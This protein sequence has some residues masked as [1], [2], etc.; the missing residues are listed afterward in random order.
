MT[1]PTIDEQIAAQ[2]QLLENY[3]PNP[4]VTLVAQSILESLRHYKAIM[5]AKLPESPYLR[6][7][8]ER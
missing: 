1:K 6:R 7:G 3:Q 2:E 4:V 8:N 5:E